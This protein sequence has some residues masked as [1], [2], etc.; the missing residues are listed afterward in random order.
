MP[1]KSVNKP[2]VELLWDVFRD[3]VWNMEGRTWK[4]EVAD[5][6]EQ[7]CRLLIRLRLSGWQ[8]KLPLRCKPWK[9]HASET[10]LLPS[11]CSNSQ[12][13]PEQER[14]NRPV[15]LARLLRVFL[16]FPVLNGYRLG[17]VRI[18]GHALQWYNSSHYLLKSFISSLF[19]I[20]VLNCT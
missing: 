9:G 3:T 14:K 15:T 5:E 16:S 19:L 8:W 13:I 11:G 17:F 18:T 10:E 12:T 1:V 7:G 4:L 2:R 20:V 6:E